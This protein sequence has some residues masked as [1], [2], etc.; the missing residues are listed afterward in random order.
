MTPVDA[1]AAAAP[2]APSAPAA[3][4]FNRDSIHLRA[5]GGTLTLF[6]HGRLQVDGLFFLTKQPTGTPTDA[7]LV[8]RARIELAGWVGSTIGFQ[9]GN[10]FGSS[11]GGTD[12]FIVI[13]PWERLAMLQVG[14]FSAPF[15]YDN[16]VSDK[17]FDF[18]E[19]SITVRAIGA[20]TNKEMGAMLHGL[21]PG[22]LGYW[23]IG[24]FDG[25]GT[26]VR[27]VDDSWDLIARAFATPFASG[28]AGILQRLEV[29]ASAWHGQRD[30]TAIA[31]NPQATA[32]GYRFMDNKWT[33]TDDKGQKTAYELRQYGK[34]RDYAVELNWPMSA[35]FGVRAEA[36]WK[37]Q[38]LAVFTTKVQS[39]TTLSAF[40]GYAMAWLWLVGS[41]AILPQDTTQALPSPNGPRPV[42]L[43]DG[44]QLIARAEYL[45]ET[46]SGDA[47]P[48]NPGQSVQAWATEMGLNYWR[49]KRFR[50]GIN[51]SLHHFENTGEAILRGGSFVQQE[52]MLRLGIAL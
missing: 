33:Y 41:D 46:L 48:G 35:T 19:R 9:I 11:P 28:K 6:P 22:R 17:Q 44:V 13:D 12:N 45:K 5:D 37:S 1:A 15:S 3:A 29:G 52:L 47:G 2:P 7:V 36:L 30:V 23:S 42:P 38:D 4:P 31:L 14:Q 18:A 27:N 32:A 40:A 49:S 39:T 25:D 34:L 51:Y 50:A 21:V 26:N 16:V 10:D 43:V 20:P 8:R 24:L